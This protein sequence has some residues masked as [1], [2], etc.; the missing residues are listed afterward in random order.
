MLWG[1]SFLWIKLALRGF[2]PGQVVLVRLGLGALFLLALCWVRGLGPPRSSR[3]WAKIAVAAVFANFVPYLLYGIAEQQV[4]SSLAGVL[5]AST[6]LWTMAIALGVRQET[7][8]GAGRGTGLVLGFAGTLLCFSPWEAG[9]ALGGALLCLAPAACYGIGYVYTRR[10]LTGSGVEPV[11]MVAAQL[12]VATGLAALTIPVTGSS[13]VSV[14]ADA[15][16][17]MAVLGMLCTG[18]AYLFNFRLTVEDGSTVASTV[19]Y[20]LPIVSVLLGMAFLAEPFRWN[21]IA[22]MAVALAGV[23]LVQRSPGPTTQPQRRPEPA[24]SRSGPGN[25]KD[26]HE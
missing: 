9:G 1:S 16:L 10:F 4:D 8:V 2:S 11:A 22:G 20:L 24:S 3:L 17:A 26:I 25:E 18:V 7:S 13:P 12:L 14:R 5:N 6:P 23:A 19:T 15:F 21:A